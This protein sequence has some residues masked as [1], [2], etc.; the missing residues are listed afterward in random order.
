MDGKGLMEIEVRTAI[1]PETGQTY[2]IKFPTSEVVQQEILKLEYP[3][4]GL[5][6]AQA[7]EIL[8]EKLG[9]SDE[10]KEAKSKRGEKYLRYF[11]HEIV[12]PAFGKLFKEGKLIQ[13]GGSHKPYMPPQTEAPSSNSDDDM[14]VGTGGP[15]G[16]SEIDSIEAI[17]QKNMKTLAADLL[18]KIKANSPAFFERLVI[19]LL[20][21]MGYGGSREDAAEAVGGSGDGGIDGIIKEDRLGLDKIYVQAK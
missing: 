17:Y 19:D 5:M 11:H 8:T 21:K 20:V 2:S 13:P 4:D 9:L 16:I 10:Q 1:D 3:L 7:T 6:M 12:I 14:P 18:E 15:N